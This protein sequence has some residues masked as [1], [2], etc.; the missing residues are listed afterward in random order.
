MVK[1]LFSV[2]ITVILIFSLCACSA[3]KEFILSGFSADVSFAM[4][5]E[6]VT[7]RLDFKGK[8]NIYF[9]IIKPENLEGITFT[10]STANIDDV[11]INYSNFKDESPVFL[12][13]SIVEN[14]SECQILL[15]LEGE[16]TLTGETS[17][18]EYK[19]IFDCEK[20]KIKRIE[21][22]KFTYNFE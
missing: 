13:L 22:G 12:L 14:L 18:A 5:E 21:T 17:S 10:K 2:L 7:G 8:D 1:S 15:P 3:E 16:F 4:D 11:T 20:E 19:A 6:F 9:T